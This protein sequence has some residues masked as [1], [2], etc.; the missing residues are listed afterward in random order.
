MVMK[1]LLLQNF[2]L[3]ILFSFISTF[4]FAQPE[5]CGS[6]PAMTSTCL[7]AC[8]IC[9]I[10]GFTGRNDLTIQGQGFPIF[11]TTQFHNMSYIAFIAGT[12]D[13]TI[14]VTVT[15]CTINWGLEIGIFESFDCQN[16]NPISVCNTDVQP[17]S[18]A[19]FSNNTPLVVGQHYYL[20]MDGSAG[21]ICDWTFDVLDGSTAV[22]PLVSSGNISGNETTCPNF[23]TT[24]ATTGTTGAALFFWT[25][26][27][28]PQTAT[29]QAIDLSFPQDGFYEVCVTAANVCNDAPPTCTIVTVETPGTLNLVEEICDNDCYEVAGQ[30][31]CETGIFYFLITLPNGCDSLIFLDLTVLPQAQETIDI[32]LCVGEEFFVGTTPYSTTGIFVDTIFTAA[33]CDSIV[34]LDLFMIE[35]EIMG[36]TDFISPIC[37][38]DAN[39][40]L[41]FSVENG[42]P[43]FTFVWEHITDVAISGNGNTLLFTNNEIE[44]VPAGFYEINIMDDFGNDVVLFQEVLEPPVLT[45]A[46]DA[47]TIDDFNLSCNGGMDGTAT[48]A[49][50]GG[51]SPYTYLWSDTQIGNQTNNLLAGTYTVSVT[52]DNGCVQ[53]NNITLTEP[54]MIEYTVNFIDP[55]CDGFETG[56]I[57]VDSVFGGTPPY[58]FALDEMPF[59][60]TRL[61]ENLSGGNYEVFI[62]DDNDCIVEVNGTLTPPDIPVLFM[63]DDLEVALGCD[64]LIPVST[65]NT[66]LVEI[67][68]T[69]GDGTLDCVT[70]LRPTASPVD[71]TEYFLTVTSID[72]CTTSDSIIID[73]T[74]ARDIFAPTGFTPNGDGFND[75]FYL[76]TNKSAT[77]IKNIKVFN[78]WGAIV[79]EENDLPPNDISTGWD[80]FFN[81]RLVNS[82]VYVWIAEIEYLDGEVVTASGDVTL[83]L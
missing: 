5:P 49:G 65:N 19:I 22:N 10:D 69:G 79:Y 52:D 1:N 30:T 8:A 73:V 41:I 25:I 20:I 50:S 18:T 45:V 17:N 35:C 40:R 12:E 56:L 39:G 63:G 31:I 38:G 29:S 9:D 75:I 37:N 7:E 16:F 28:T 58:M 55:N 2:Y 51:V 64:I 11:C 6:D 46:T 42:T 48:A 60:S 27:G 44:N 34:T 83:V 4:S 62:Q 33:D 80:G 47:I 3:L 53:E 24:Y 70:C 66:N 71:L 68:W 15:N 21:D 13:L 26:N 43:P 61:Y 81:G 57:Q 82:G 59:N 32:N 77:L 36:S 14:Q 72:N 74:K 76:N 23:P 54:S 67:Q 78:R